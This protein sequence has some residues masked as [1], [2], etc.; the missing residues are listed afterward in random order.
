MSVMTLSVAIESAA[1]SSFPIGHYTPLS[2][3][4]LAGGEILFTRLRTT[5]LS[6]VRTTPTEAVDIAKASFGDGSDTRVVLVS[7]GG[8]VNKNDI[9]HDWSGTKAFIPRAAPS[10]IVRLFE[11]HLVTLDPSDDHYWNVVVNAKSGKIIL[12]F[13]Y[14]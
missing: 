7:L 11:P 9:V 1:T 6:S 4:V 5:E 8:Y 12:A 14:D 2:K 3:S 10:Y 13:S